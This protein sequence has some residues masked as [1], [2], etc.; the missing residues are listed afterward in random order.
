LPITDKQSFLDKLHAAL[1]KRGIADA[2]I[3]PYIERFD[4]FYDRMISDQSEVSAESLSDIENIAD[5]IAAQIGER[6]NEINR[7]AERT[8]T[9]GTV[10]ADDPPP[11]PLPKAMP[12]PEPIPEEEDYE[13]VEENPPTG[14]VPASDGLEEIF[15]DELEEVPSTRL[16]DY[17][18][19]EPAPNSTMFWVLFAVSLPVTVPLALAGLAVFLAVWAAM[20]ALILAAVGALVLLTAGGSAL[21]LVGI[22][23]GVI[24]LFSVVPVGLYEIGMGVIIAGGIMFVG[25]LIYNVAVRLLPFLMRMVWRLFCFVLKK[26][27]VLFNFL[28]RECAKL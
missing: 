15:D 21:S 10:K 25:I 20:I 19:E 12:A 23:Y 17:E 11:A 18:E 22:I 26:L 13:L 16:P 2:D 9:M 8:M 3:R 6:Y 1:V 4:R 14:L 24:Q 27:R 5:N 7:L 28:R